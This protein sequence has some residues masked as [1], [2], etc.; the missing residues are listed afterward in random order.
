D[1]ERGEALRRELLRGRIEIAERNH[2]APAERRERRAHAIRTHHGKRAERNAVIAPLAM[3]D[4][5]A[6][7]RS[8]RKL[9]R[10]IDRLRPAV[11]EVRT[12]EV[13]PKARCEMLR[14]KPGLTW[15]RELDERREIRRERVL[16]SGDQLGMVIP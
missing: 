16:R 10:A 8:E 3:E 2:V 7:C 1:D 6:A 14:E 15:R 13:G 12:R 4:A 5:H 9:Q 11:R